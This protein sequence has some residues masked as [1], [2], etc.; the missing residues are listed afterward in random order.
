MLLI[1]SRLIPIASV[2]SPAAL[3]SEMKPIYSATTC[4]AVATLNFTREAVFNFRDENEKD[5]PRLSLSY[6]NTTDPD[7]KAAGYFD[8]Y[9]QP[10]KNAR[11]L[12]FAS[13]YL[14]RS[15]VRTNARIDF[16]GE[17]WNCT[18]SINFVGPGYK[19]NDISNTNVSGAPFGMDALAPVGNFTYLSE[20]FQDDYVSPQ[21]ETDNGVPAHGPPYPA[22]LGVFQSEPILWIGYANKTDD[23]YPDD[24]PYAAKWKYVHVPNMF[25]CVM[26]HTNY[27]FE[28]R[29]EPSQIANLKQRDFLRPTVNTN[30]SLSPG[31]TADWIATPDSNWVR[32][33][34][35]REAYKMTAAY[36]SL[37]ALMRTFLLGNI[38]KTSDV[39]LVTRSDISETKL[40]NVNNPYPVPN[41]MDAVQNLF[42]DMLITLLSEPTLVVADKAAVPCQKRQDVVVY[43]YYK[44][45]LWI[46]Y[47][48]VIA[49]TFAF[50]LVG[51]WSIYQN[52]VASDVLFSR[53]MVTTRNPTLDHL[54]VGACLGGDPFPKE[55]TETKLRFGVLLEDDPREGPLGKV[56]HCTFGT[57]GETKEIVKGGTYAGLK[58]WRK[59]NRQTTGVSDEEKTLLVTG[60][61]C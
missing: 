31:S 61:Q 59:D 37:G 3:T 13:A 55:L 51:F 50:I 52:G 38:E 17:G 21:I 33:S 40:I 32:P 43:R 56:E 46:G 23:L 36:H 11:R 44:R 39:L 30:I 9:D 6:Y 60:Y 42:Q 47:A 41:L 16:C 26:H 49:I 14:R 58:K 7:G 45:S 2:L 28:M 8:Y 10:T 54:S 19:C 18:Y 57:I 5:I 35:D 53:I 24:S 4:P 22:T 48:V 12:A 29:Y 34:T 1:A 25:M 20:V 15:Q 27:T